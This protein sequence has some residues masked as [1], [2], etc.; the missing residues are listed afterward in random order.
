MTQELNRALRGL[1]VGKPGGASPFP[2]FFGEEHGCLRNKDAN[3][4]DQETRA[5]RKKEHEKKRQEAS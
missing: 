5:Y 3:A 1:V 2:V 4:V